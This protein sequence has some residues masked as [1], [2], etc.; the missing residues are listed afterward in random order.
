MSKPRHRAP[1][2]AGFR[3]FFWLVIFVG[4][5]AAAIWVWQRNARPRPGPLYRETGWLP[6]QPSDRWKCI[7]IHHSAGEAGGAKRF[8]AFHRARGWEGLGYHFVIGNGSDT[9]DGQVEVGYRWQRQEHG[10][11]CKTD[12]NYY[13]EHGI[14]ICLVGNLNNHPP[15]ARQMISLTRLVRFLC[16]EFQI[17]QS[18]ILTHGGVTHKTECPGKEFDMGQLKKMING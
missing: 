3:A 18:R 17:P 4:L 6:A 13:N 5:A 1:A 14:G 10:A 9:P 11:H 7:V 12:D 2:H 16:A 15:T 8:D